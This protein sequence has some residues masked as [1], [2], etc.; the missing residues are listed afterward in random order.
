LRQILDAHLV[1]GSS[2]SNRNIL[3]E[4]NSRR[5]T[6]HLGLKCFSASLQVEFPKKAS[7]KNKKI[8]C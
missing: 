8:W 6:S 7:L 4:I 5:I 3:D 2:A 1:A